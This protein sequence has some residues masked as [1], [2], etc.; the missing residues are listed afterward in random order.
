MRA[1]LAVLLTLAAQAAAAQ[2]VAPPASLRPTLQQVRDAFEPDARIVRG[3][4]P[5][6]TTA[7]HDLRDWVEARLAA[8]DEAISPV[9]FS[10]ALHEALDASGLLCTDFQIECGQNFLG[11][12]DDVRVRRQGAYLTVITAMGVWCGYDESAYLYGWDGAAWRRVWAHER[13]TYTEDEYLPQEIADV[14]VSA[15]DA[16]GASTILLLGSQAACNGA[17]KNLYARAWQLPAAG[18]PTQVLDWVEFANDGYPPIQGRVRPGD[19]L[20]QYTEDGL[21]SGDPHTAVRHFRVENGTAVQAD[22][23]AGRPHDFVAEWLS[24]PWEE[25]RAWSESDAL[26]A[27]HTEL[28]NEDGFGDMPQPTLRCGVDSDLWQVTTAV[29]RGPTRYYRVRWTA[30]YRF[31]LVAVSEAPYPDC[32]IEDPRGDAYDDLLRA[33]EVD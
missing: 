12:I 30:P 10:G 11:Y 27:A 2:A 29:F 20:F 23:I 21:A 18:E 17:F 4:T 6:L 14:L 9:A 3:A 22:P 25:S 1:I 26:E 8:E 16:G 28:A 19:V 13:L 31:T 24:M 7:K 33:D 32:T 15:P 5:A